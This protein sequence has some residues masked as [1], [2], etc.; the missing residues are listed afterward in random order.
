MEYFSSL[1]KRR[2]QSSRKINGDA[3][4]RWEKGKS[5]GDGQRATSLW[6]TTEASAEAAA[7]RCG[8]T[9]DFATVEVCFAEQMILKPRGVGTLWAVHTSHLSVGP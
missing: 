1:G 2:K 8:G 9:S 6:D 5:R 3:I 4:I 7:S